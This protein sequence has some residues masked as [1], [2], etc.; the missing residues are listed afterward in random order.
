MS[1][2]TDKQSKL[3]AECVS[4]G[5]LTVGCNGRADNPGH[6]AKYGSYGIIDLDSNKV[7]HMELV[8][9]STFIYCSVSELKFLH[10]AMNMEHSM[11]MEHRGLVSALKYL[12]NSSVQIDKLITDRHKQIFILS[13]DDTKKVAK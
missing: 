7:I 3:L 2:W 11:H 12:D 4:K 1:V 9:V 8:Q 6:S 13:N 10:R 5:P